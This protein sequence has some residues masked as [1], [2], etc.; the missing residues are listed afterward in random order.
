M[1]LCLDTQITFIKRVSAKLL[2]QH[3]KRPVHDIIEKNI[4]RKITLFLSILPRSIRDTKN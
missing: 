1:Q 2:N 4:V 3:T